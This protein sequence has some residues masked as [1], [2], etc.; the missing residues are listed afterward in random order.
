MANINLDRDT[1]FRRLKKLYAAWQSPDGE[2]GFSKMDCLV[3][4]VGVDEEM[5]Y[6]KSGALQTWLLGYELT[7]TIMVRIQE[8]EL[9]SLFFFKLFYNNYDIILMVYRFIYLFSRIAYFNV[10]WF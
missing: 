10:F 1:F 5:V 8:F 2:N 9:F 7:D 3:T 6:S 4:A